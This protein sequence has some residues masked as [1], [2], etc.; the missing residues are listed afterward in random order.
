MLHSKLVAMRVGGTAATVSKATDTLD[1]L[2]FVI[3]NSVNGS[4][5]RYQHILSAKPSTTAHSSRSNINYVKQ[6]SI[7][8]KKTAPTTTTFVSVFENN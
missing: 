6:Y 3:K 4:S 1:R 5:R 8:S 2:Q 7:L